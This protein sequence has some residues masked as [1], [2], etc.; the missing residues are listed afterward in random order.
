[1]SILKKGMRLKMIKNGKKIDEVKVLSVSGDG[2]KIEVESLR[3]NPGD[4]D[5]Y[6]LVPGLG[7]RSLYPDPFTGVTCFSKDEAACDFEF[8]T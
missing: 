5:E 8:I 6:G 2:C 1:M 7:W 3:L 4:A